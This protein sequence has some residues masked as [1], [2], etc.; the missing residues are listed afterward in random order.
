MGEEGEEEEEAAA[1]AAAEVARHARRWPSPTTNKAI[2]P[3][4]HTHH[5]PNQG[6]RSFHEGTERRGRGGKGKS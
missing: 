6:V 5:T 2:H 3:C 1:A 4:T